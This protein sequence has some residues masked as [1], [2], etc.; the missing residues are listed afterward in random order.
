VPD[1]VTIELHFQIANHEGGR[2]TA[3]IGAITCFDC[4]NDPVDRLL[5]APKD[6]HQTQSICAFWVL[7]AS[8][9]KCSL[10]RHLA[11]VSS[12]A[13]EIVIYDIEGGMAHAATIGTTLARVD[14]ERSKYLVPSAGIL[15]P[16]VIGQI[17]DPKAGR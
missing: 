13:F 11:G 2:E 9:I 10:I 16:K 1:I 7:S 17:S 8:G 14:G 3:M 4:N 5:A 6:R 12:L 15:T